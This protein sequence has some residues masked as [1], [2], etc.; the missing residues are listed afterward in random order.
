MSKAGL[1]E[2]IILAENE[3]VFQVI[4]IARYILS[5]KELNKVTQGDISPKV[6]PGNHQHST[7][8][9]LY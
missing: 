4:F 1:S 7:S 6:I 2:D 8:Y 5:E 3:A 9:N